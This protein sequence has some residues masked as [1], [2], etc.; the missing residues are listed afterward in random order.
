MTRPHWE[1]LTQDET[2]ALAGSETTFQCRASVAA[3]LWTPNNAVKTQ[4]KHSV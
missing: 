4:L 1:S 2:A 3:E